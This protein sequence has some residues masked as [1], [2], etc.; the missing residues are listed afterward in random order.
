MRRLNMIIAVPSSLSAL[1]IVA[2]LVMATPTSAHNGVKQP[3]VMARMMAMGEIGKATKTLSDMARGITPLH[4]AKARMAR[5]TIVTKAGKLPGLFKTPAIDP[6][7]EALP[8]IWDN[9]ADFTAR[10]ES[11]K[12]AAIGL[13]FSDKPALSAS[14]RALGAT[15]GGCHK[16]YRIEK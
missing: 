3:D 15:C 9:W 16:R 7:S 8:Q 6:K 14:L 10:S 12:Q 5:D 4:Q 13:E 11:M 2:A 1:A